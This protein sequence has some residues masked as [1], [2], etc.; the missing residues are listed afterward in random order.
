MNNLE[1]FEE[2]GCYYSEE[3][4]P[5]TCYYCRYYDECNI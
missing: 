5:M 1:E 3:D 4:R 2:N